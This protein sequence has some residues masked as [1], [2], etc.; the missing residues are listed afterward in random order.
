MAEELKSLGYNLEK[1]SPESIVITNKT[2]YTHFLENNIQDICVAN[3]MIREESVKELTSKQIKEAISKGHV[4]PIEFREEILA[5]KG[6]SLFIERNPNHLLQEDLQ[7]MIPDFNPDNHKIEINGYEE[8]NRK[9]EN[10]FLDKK[11]SVMK[12]SSLENVREGNKLNEETKI[13]LKF[14]LENMSKNPAL[15]RKAIDS[16]IKNNPKNKQL[17]QAISN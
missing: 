12:Y 1:I 6:K 10:L 16:L 7:Q 14:A 8:V 11:L 13:I 2:E 15:I 3:A 9:A 4:L 5:E 17:K